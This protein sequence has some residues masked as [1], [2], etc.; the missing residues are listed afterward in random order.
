MIKKIV[1]RY[2]ARPAFSQD[3]AHGQAMRRFGCCLKIITTSLIYIDDI[4]TNSTKHII[5]AKP[6]SQPSLDNKSGSDSGGEL[7]KTNSTCS[8]R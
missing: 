3:G 2:I 1:I 4:D 5:R 6:G 7:N 8:G